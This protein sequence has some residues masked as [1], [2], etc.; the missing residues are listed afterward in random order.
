MSTYPQLSG[1]PTA[2]SAERQKQR[3]QVDEA[4]RWR[5]KYEFERRKVIFLLLMLQLVAGSYSVIVVP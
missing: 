1:D 3:S 2:E 5:E 4:E